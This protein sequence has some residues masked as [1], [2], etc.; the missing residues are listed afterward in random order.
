MAE[1][2]KHPRMV[3]AGRKKRGAHPEEKVFDPRHIA[4]MDYSVSNYKAIPAG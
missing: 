1:K 2:I 4:I 3:G